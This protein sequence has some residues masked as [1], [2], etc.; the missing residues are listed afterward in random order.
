MYV[1]YG[2]ETCDPVLTD[3][4]FVITITNAVNTVYVFTK[5]VMFLVSCTMTGNEHN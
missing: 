3:R 1:E 2:L 4:C 5:D